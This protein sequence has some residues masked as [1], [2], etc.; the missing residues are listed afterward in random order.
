[1]TSVLQDLYH[2]VNVDS[3]IN[4]IGKISVQKAL[5]SSFSEARQAIM[6]KCMEIFS[7]YHAAFVSNATSQLVSPDS[8]KAFPLQTLALIKHASL[9]V[10]TGLQL[11][12]RTAAIH[13]IR[14]APVSAS[15]L[16]LYPTLYS[17]GP[18]LSAASMGLDTQAL[19]ELPPQMDLSTE[20]L[21]QNGVYLLCGYQ[22]ILLWV[23]SMTPPEV[24]HSLFAISSLN[25]VDANNS[26]LQLIP[27]EN[28]HSMRVQAIL[29]AARART[30]HYLPIIPMKQG[31]RLESFFIQS[32]IHDRV[33]SNYSYAEFLRE[34]QSIVLSKTQR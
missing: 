1:V 32:L 4:L 13:L 17:I 6:N 30:P 16:L 23:G 25:E 31:E 21:S 19:Q 28:P 3:C 7:K 8:L 34:L 27:L 5:N 9:R 33:L 2:R 11:D 15:K 10:A 18:D 24:L 20:K 29:N 14:S 26:Q 12:E 22:Y